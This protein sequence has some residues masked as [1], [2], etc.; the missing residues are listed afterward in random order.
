MPTI[1]IGF[2]ESPN[3]SAR[4]SMVRFGPSLYVEIGFDPSFRTDGMNRPNL[5][6]S[7][8]PALVDTGASE[9][10]I[11]STLAEQLGLPIVGR[12]SVAGAHGAAVVNL[13]LAQIIVPAFQHIVYGRFAGVHLVE[14]GQRH[15]AL[16]G[17]TF[18]MN[19]GM[20]YDGRTGVVTLSDE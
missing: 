3:I 16:L 11:D 6:N 20:M 15:Q 8:F 10:C 18:L 14:G 9:S 5:P 17:R 12:H 4:D 1:N 13:H 2:P 19:F 7:R